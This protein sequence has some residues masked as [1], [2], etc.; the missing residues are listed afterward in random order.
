MIL[1]IIRLFLLFFSF[2]SFFISSCS[3]TPR[4]EIA[5]KKHSSGTSD[6]PDKIQFQ[7]EE[8]EIEE[9]QGESKLSLKPLKMEDLES[10]NS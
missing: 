9:Y 7:F 10:L 1:S 2:S 4:N 3:N 5:T 6:I 8:Y